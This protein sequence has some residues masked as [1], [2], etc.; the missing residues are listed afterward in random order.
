MTLSKH[1]SALALTLVAAATLS[2]EDSP[3]F[4]VASIKASPELSPQT[5]GGLTI[6]ARQARFS[7]LSL[8]DYIGIGFAVKLHQIVGPDWLAKARF[9]VVATIPENQKADQ[10]APMMRALLEDRFKLRTHRD[11]K[12][13]DVYA[14]EVAP[15]AKLVKIPDETST[16]A[17][18]EVSST[19]TAGGAAIDLGQGSS[20]TL[21]NNRFDAKKV[22]M[23]TLADILGRFVDRPVVDMTKLEGRYNVL[24][25]LQPEDF[26]AMMIRSAVAS[27][28]SMPPQALQM[29]DRA[30]IAAV[31]DALRSLGLKMTPRKA[32]LE[33]LV[34][35]GIEK[36]PT[37][38]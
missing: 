33:V 27:G 36:L 5:R 21:S 9:E 23:T 18:F 12:E 32:P 10:L 17:V 3:R 11:S 15:D 35:D 26:V 25:D 37:E 14:L 8:N 16:A 19:P 4:E 7:M 22:N 28:V 29:L 31:P 1:L 6:T 13:F 38:N 24:F 20:L 30:S 2:A 34:I